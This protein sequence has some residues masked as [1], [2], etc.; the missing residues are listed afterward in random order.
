MI[1]IYQLL[2]FYF[3][4]KNKSQIRKKIKNK[5]NNQYLHK[6]QHN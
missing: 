5:R 6:K 2:G 4:K 3:S 1:V